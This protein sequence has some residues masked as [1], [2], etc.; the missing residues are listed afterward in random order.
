[1][2]V[3][4]IEHHTKTK[5]KVCLDNRTDFQLYKSEIDKYDIVE[6]EELSNYDKI[7]NEVLIP[8]AKK[9]AMHLLEKMDR[10]EA[11]IRSKLIRNGYPNEA[12][13]AAIEYIESY[14]YL[15]D[16]R[17]AYMYVR[18]YCNS[19]SRNRIMQDLYRKGIDKNTINDALASEY[20]VNE[21]DLIK[22]Y[23]D[24]REYDIDNASAKDRDKMFRFLIS[25]GFRIEEIQHLI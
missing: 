2:I 13:D 4:S 14:N 5:V 17:Y 8:R 25:K 15:S 16:E 11:D 6:G 20:T 10:T 12:I 7:L 21:E 24:K 18:N 22:M 3:T 23:I 19:R 1:M 9:R